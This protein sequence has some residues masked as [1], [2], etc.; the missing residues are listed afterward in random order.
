ME[1]AAPHVAVAH[2]AREAPR[3]VR[4]SQNIGG[5]GNITCLLPA[6]RLE[7]VFAFD[8]GP[9]NMVMDAVLS[10]LTGG[11]QTYDAGGEFAAAGTVHQGLLNWLMED[12][13]LV[14][15]PPKTTGR[16]YYGPAYVA[17][18]MD[19]AHENRISDADLMATVTAFTAETIRYSVEHYFPVKPDRLIIGGG[20]SMNRTLVQ[21]I[22]K[23]L[24]GCKVMTNEE[25]GYDS[26]A[27]EAVA[28]AV[29]ANEAIFAGCNNVPSVTGAQNPVVMGKISL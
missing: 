24:P 21:D 15:K 25:L 10:E 27:K 29:M 11:K 3:V 17:K 28:F 22:A 8:T 2:D 18:I 9:G 19:F 4:A 1:L 14:C 13:Y 20:G 5:I 6:C 23:A 7:D 12:P 26:N 16:E